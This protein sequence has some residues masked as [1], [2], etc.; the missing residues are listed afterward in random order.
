MLFFERI[1]RIASWQEE[2]LPAAVVANCLGRHSLSLAVIADTL[3]MCTKDN[4]QE[5]LMPLDNSIP[6]RMMA[7]FKNHVDM[8][9]N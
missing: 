8:P 7:V 1:A 5:F 4:I 3:K 9:E 6:K 2:R